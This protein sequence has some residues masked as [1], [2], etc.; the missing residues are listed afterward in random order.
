MCMGLSSYST[1][2]PSNVQQSS[3][4]EASYTLEMKH[5]TLAGGIPEAETWGIPKPSHGCG[6]NLQASQ[7]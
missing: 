3:R 2:S 7:V 5:W 1:V 6:S 4:C